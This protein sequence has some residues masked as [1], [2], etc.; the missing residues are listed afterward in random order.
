MEQLKITLADRIM[1]LVCMLSAS[2]GWSKTKDR[3]Y[4]WRMKEL[5]QMAGEAEGASQEAID[6]VCEK[7]A[8]YR[9]SPDFIAEKLIEIW[10]IA[11]KNEQQA[12]GK[13]DPKATTK[14]ARHETNS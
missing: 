8:R 4:Q 11:W 7:A 6:A 5:I 3:E 2:K 9:N 12:T 10:A 1:Q 13:V 14:G